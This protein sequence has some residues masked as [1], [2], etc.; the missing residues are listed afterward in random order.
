MALAAPLSAAPLVTYTVT[1][2]PGGLAAYDLYFEEDTGAAVTWFAQKWSFTGDIKQTL[3]FGT[4]PVMKEADA[5][6]YD[7]L[8]VNGS[9][10]KKLE[11]TWVGAAFVAFPLDTDLDPPPPNPLDEPG[12]FEVS[13]ATDPTNKL[14]QVLFAHIVASGPVQYEGKIALSG[15]SQFFDQAGT[16][17]I[18]EPS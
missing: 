13:S 14:S 15:S 10:Y 12:L 11:D 1:P 8:Q 4:V 6:T 5:N 2:L 18:P 17:A 7:A 9:N 3:A 16:L